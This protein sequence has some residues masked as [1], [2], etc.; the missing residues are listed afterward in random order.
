MGQIL[1]PFAAQKFCG[2]FWFKYVGLRMP[3]VLGQACQR[4]ILVDFL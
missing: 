3:Y 2:C 1:G 4:R